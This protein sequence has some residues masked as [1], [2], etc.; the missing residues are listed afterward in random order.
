MHY[1]L[2]RNYSPLRYPGGKRRLINAVTRLLEANRLTDIDYLEPYA[3]SATV[4]LAL[5]FEEHAAT[6]HINDLSRPIYG[7]WNT[8]LKNPD[9]ICSR[10]EAAELTIAEWKE[11]REIYRMRDTAELADLG[12]AALYLNRTNRSGIIGG[13][14]IGG[15]KQTGK[16][17]ID[18]RFNRPELIRRIRKIHRYKTRIKLYQRD[19]LQFIQDVLPQLRKNAFIFFDPPYIENGRHM[20]LNNYTLEDHVG[21]AAQ[22]EGIQQPWIVTYDYSAVRHR[23]YKHRRRI[24]YGLKYS[25]QNRYEGKEVMFLAD[26]L[27]VPKLSELAG[28]TMYML[29][30]QSR[31]HL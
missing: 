22:I 21:L 8:I 12:F 7:M 20:Y 11:Q 28:P 17:K 2:Q 10:I 13:G 9:D 14:V 29:P 23:L 3:G 30:L 15:Q 5:L 16:W 19:A 27:H 1:T 6:I 31:L 25:A 4:A 26:G 24:V 18:A